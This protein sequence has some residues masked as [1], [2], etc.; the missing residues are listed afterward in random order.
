MNKFKRFLVML[1]VCALTLTESNV[2][3]LRATE[4]ETATQ[5]VDPNVATDLTDPNAATDPV[6]P[7]TDPN[8]ATDPA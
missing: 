6:N 2:L 3:I 8:V 7:P 1:M 4:N 5:T